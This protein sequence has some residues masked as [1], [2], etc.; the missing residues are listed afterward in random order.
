MASHDNDTVLRHAGIDRLFHWFTAATMIVLLATRFSGGSGG[1]CCRVT[2]C[3]LFAP[4][5]STPETT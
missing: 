3:C 2:G 1:N 4:G 5:C